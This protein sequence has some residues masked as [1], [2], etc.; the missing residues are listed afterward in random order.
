MKSNMSKKSQYMQRIQ[1]TND[2]FGNIGTPQISDFNRGIW[3]RGG[4]SFLAE[5]T[6]QLRLRFAL[7]FRHNFAS[8]YARRPIMPKCRRVE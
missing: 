3:C 5:L 6:I 1:N 4:G 7:L 2:R 8:H